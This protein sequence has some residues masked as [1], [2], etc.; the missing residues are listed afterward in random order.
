MNAQQENEQ[1]ERGGFWLF[2]A[3][4]TL[5]MAAIVWP[6]YKAVLWST[7]AAIMFQPLY[8][9]LLERWPM[10]PSRCALATMLIITFAVLLPAFF[11]GGLVVDEAVSVVAAFQRGNI[12]I[13]GMLNQI[14]DALPINVL[15]VL[16][17]NGWGDIADLQDRAQEFATEIA[18][19]VASQAVAVGGGVAS[20]AL[21]FGIGLYVTYF[22]LRDGRQIGDAVVSSLPLESDI[23]KRLVD[24]FLSIVRATIKGSGVVGVVQGA[25]GA[26]TFWIAGVP[27]AILF[28]VLMALFSLLPAV[29]TGIVWV[30]VAIWLLATGAIW[31][32]ILVIVSGIAV[33]GMA[34]NLL[35]PMLV[36]R[37]TGIPDW[38]ILITTLGGLSWMGL[39]GIV[40]GPLVAGLF[41]AGWSIADEHRSIPPS[42]D[43]AAPSKDKAAV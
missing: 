20:F 25:L 33:I 16:E 4:V 3:L 5:A 9:R 38:I 17:A 19:Y 14:R 41:L 13:P 22:L 31:Q 30:P 39:S 6:F 23:A 18:T 26:I 24:K 40:V 15:A 8:R 10:H 7:L 28:G 1:I 34:D 21:A 42:L 43:D 11:I 12:D 29:G 36:G 35:R 37:D 2:L 32:G 27:S